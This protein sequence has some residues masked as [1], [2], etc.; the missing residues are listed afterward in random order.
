MRP[1]M[2]TS[3][4]PIHSI[5]YTKAKTAP[6]Y[7]QPMYLCTVYCTSQKHLFV[8][9]LGPCTH[10]QYKSKTSAVFSHHFIA[11]VKPVIASGQS[12]NLQKHQGGGT[13]NI[14]FLCALKMPE[15]RKHTGTTQ[16]TQSVD[17]QYLILAYENWT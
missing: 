8:I 16:C 10:V 17:V 14:N 6:C 13:F 11:V 12:S 15:N 5:L 4:V 9:Q 2:P 1:V 3:H 7:S